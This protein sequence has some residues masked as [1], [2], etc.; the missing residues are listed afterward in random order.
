MVFLGNGP[1]TVKLF[2]L[3]NKFQIKKTR[4]SV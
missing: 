3:F 4:K 1:Y 2:I